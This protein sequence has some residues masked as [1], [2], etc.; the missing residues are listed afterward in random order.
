MIESPAGNA[1][2]AAIAAYLALTGAVIA[3]TPPPPRGPL[4]ASI[5][6]LADYKAKLTGTLLTATGTLALLTALLLGYTPAI[7]TLLAGTAATIIA[8]T[9]LP[10][11][12]AEQLLLTTPPD[13]TQANTTAPH[14]TTP[15]TNNS[16]TS[17][18]NGHTQTRATTT[19]TS[20]GN[21]TPDAGN[22][23]G[24]TRGNRDTSAHG[25]NRDSRGREPCEEDSSGSTSCERAPTTTSS[26]PLVGNPP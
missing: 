14:D 3:R 24:P 8:A 19:R 22:T 13:G 9:L 16:A 2:A 25:A 21:T 18:G 7:T 5:P 23:R 20:P 15:P 12:K 26:P 1:L 11:R 17:P 4:E 6:K 10:P